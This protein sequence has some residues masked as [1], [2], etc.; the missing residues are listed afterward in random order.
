M[1]MPKGRHEQRIDAELVAELVA[2]C[3]SLFAMPVPEDVH[4]DYTDQDAA[5]DR[6]RGALQR[7]DAS[8]VRHR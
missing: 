8:K 3:R 4:R 7:I 6:I 2:A 1:T 5:L